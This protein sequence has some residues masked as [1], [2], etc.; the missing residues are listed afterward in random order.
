MLRATL[1]HRDN[2]PARV[3]GQARLGPAVR[4]R[5]AQRVEG[6]AGGPSRHIPP[7]GWIDSPDWY[8]LY[9]PTTTST[10]PVTGHVEARRSELHVAVAVRAGRGT[11]R[12]RVR[13]RRLGRG[14]RAV[15]RLAGVDQPQ[16][17]PAVVLERGV[18]LSTTKSLETSEKYTVTLRIRVTDASGRMGEERRTIAVHHDPRGAGFPKRIGRGGESQPALVDLQG[19]GAWPSC[20]A[21]P[22]AGCTPSTLSG[23]GA[24]GVA[25]AHRPDGGDQGAPGDRPR[26]RAD[27]EQR[28]RRRPG[29][30]GLPEGRRDDDD[31]HRVRLQRQRQAPRR[32]GRRRSTS[33][34]TSRPSRARNSRSPASPRGARPRHPC[35]PTSTATAS[36]RSS[37]RAGTGTSTL[38]HNDGTTSRA[39]RST[40][41][42]SFTAPAGYSAVKDRK[43]VVPPDDRRPRRRR[44]PEVVIRSQFTEVPGSVITFAAHGHLLRVQGQRHARGGL[45]ERLHH[46]VAEYYGSAQEFITEGERADRRRRGRRRQRRGRALGRVLRAFVPLRG[47]RLSAAAYG[48]VRRGGLFGG[49]QDAIRRCCGDAAREVAATFTTSG[50]FGTFGLGLATPSRA[51][52]GRRSSTRSSC[53]VAAT[54]STTWSAPSRRRRR[55]AAGLPRSSR[56]WT[57]SARRSSPTSPVTAARAHQRRRLLGAARLHDHRDAGDRV[58]EVLHRLEPLHRPQATSTPTATRSWSMLTREGYLFVWNTPGSRART[59]VALQPRRA[60]HGR[61]TAWT[62]GPPGILRVVPGRPRGGPES[63]SKNTAPRRRLVPRQGGPL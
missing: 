19:T 18:T 12:G 43:L 25:R 45:P 46:R 21:T 54:P 33:A 7:V 38:W 57:S 41:D 10:V 63:P 27:R 13:H 32:G 3:A 47:E 35:S 48:P 6:D 14:E 59:V 5:P 31:G 50:A 22:T 16:P 39:G 11:D 37:R 49:N 8:S 26:L 52:T 40:S 44:H 34:S 15:R 29:G 51:P 30:H 20:S 60:Q 53:P 42:A 2:P 1:G 62:R 56:G 23:R 28:R 55:R 61:P 36:S 24:A 58:P 9:D 17:R 4:L